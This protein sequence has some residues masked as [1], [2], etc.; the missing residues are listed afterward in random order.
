MY[1]VEFADGGRPAPLLGLWEFRESELSRDGHDGRFL[2]TADR[3]PG[4]SA[5]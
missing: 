2:H 3:S 4:D 1:R 5:Y